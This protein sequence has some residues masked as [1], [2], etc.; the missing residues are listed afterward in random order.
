MTPVLVDTGFLVS[1]FDPQ[2]RLAASAARYLREHKHPLATVTAVLVE[3]CFFL[4]PARKAELLTWIR[5]G[6]A[7]PIEVPVSAYGQLELTLR[8]YADRDI[9]FA[10]TALIWVANE[11][12]ARRILTVDRSD[13]EIYRLKGS[14]RFD[15]VDWYE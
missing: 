13:F 12:G 14:H 11:T 9:D 7:A 2:D 5:R 15:V 1:L 6:G 10:D 4:A 8:K 3:A